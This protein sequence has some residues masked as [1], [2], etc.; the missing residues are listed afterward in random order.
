MILSC[1]IYY[2][3]AEKVYRFDFQILKQFIILKCYI[4]K[5]YRVDTFLNHAYLSKKYLRSGDQ[6]NK[7]NQGTFMDSFCGMYLFIES[8]KSICSHIDENV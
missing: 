6:N 4:N 2:P 7:I 5:D 3:I 1:W 8:S